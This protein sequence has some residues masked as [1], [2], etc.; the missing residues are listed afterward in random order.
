MKANKEQIVMHEE[1]LDTEY[2]HMVT[3]LETLQDEKQELIE[4][5]I[6]INNENEA[7]QINL[8]SLS[9]ER[10]DLIEKDKLIKGQYKVLK[11][12]I[13]SARSEREK[14]KNETELNEK[15]HR[16]LETLLKEKYKNQE[17]S[18]QFEILSYKEFLIELQQKKVNLMQE[19][20]NLEKKEKEQETH[21]LNCREEKLLLNKNMTEQEKLWDNL[22]ELFEKVRG[23]KKLLLDED[24]VLENKFMKLKTFLVENRKNKGI[25]GQ[26]FD[27]AKNLQQKIMADFE[28]LETKKMAIEKNV[29]DESKQLHL[30]ERRSILS[31]KLENLEVDKEELLKSYDKTEDCYQQ[32]KVQ[33]NKLIEERDQLNQQNIEM[34]KAFTMLENAF[35]LM[36]VEKESV[37]TINSENN[38]V[39]KTLKE[40][41]EKLKLEKD[42]IIRKDTALAERY[43]QFCEELRSLET[44]RNLLVFKQEEIAWQNCLLSNQMN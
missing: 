27:K 34:E 5:D 23:S 21:L 37:T 39:Y 7:I 15:E 1:A 19:D 11:V 16:K 30:D 32:A 13:E 10:K 42:E 38:L 18:N 35:K 40:E 33:L 9:N 31:D 43:N 20:L 2:T 17:V 3:Q 41:Y 22:M 8:S 4:R 29:N 36:K 14:I 12:N 24:S 26:N 25:I 44:A 28:A 6:G